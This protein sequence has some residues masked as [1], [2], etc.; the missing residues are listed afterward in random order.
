[1]LLF[2]VCFL[3]IV[4]AIFTSVADSNTL[5]APAPLPTLRKSLNRHLTKSKNVVTLRQID[6]RRPHSKPF[7]P[8]PIVQQSQ[9]QKPNRPGYFHNPHSKLIR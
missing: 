9:P 3:L 7:L 4:Q 8:R 1:M 5:E 6:F 2:K